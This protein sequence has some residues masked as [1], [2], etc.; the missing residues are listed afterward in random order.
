MS[1]N[2]PQNSRANM[3]RG[4]QFTKK[5]KKGPFKRFIKIVLSLF[6]LLILFGAGLF[7]YYASSSPRITQSALSSD[8]STQI[9]D[10]NGKVISRLGSQNRDYVK[11][12]KIPGTL[13]QAVVSIED[14]RFYKHHGV[15]PIRIVGAA[16]SN[17]TGS[18]LGMQGGSTLTQQLVKL[19]V[20][21]TAASDRTLKRKAQ[22]AW[23]AIQV[24]NRY[25]KSQILEF[26]INKVYMGNGVYGM[27]TGA[28][29]YYN[30]TLG[31]LTLPQLALLAGMPQSPKYYNPYIY[32][33]YATERR[34][35]VLNAMVKNKAIT[36]AQ[37]QRA[38]NTSVKSGLAKTH[39]QTSGSAKTSKYIDS[40]LK[41]TLEELKAKGYKANS[42]LKVYTNLN[43]NAQ[44]KLYKVSNNDPSIV[45]PNNRFQVGAT[46][47]NVNNGKVMAM[48]G[49]RKTKVAF[50]L[51]RA[52]QTG[53]SSGSTAK[54]IMDYG[55]AIEYLKYPTYQPVKDTPYVYP[56][57]D[58]NV[59]D[60]DDKYQGTIT[61]RKAIVE[62]RNI[63]AIRTLENVGISKATTFLK[64]LG[65]PFKKTLSLQNGI[66]LYIS[67]EQLAASYAAFSNGGT[68]Y[69][70]Y[71]INRIV[72]ANGVTKR[73]HPK[74]KR[75]MSPATAF[76]I[77]NMLKGVMTDSDGS[78]TTAKI[79]GLY[80]AGKTGTTQYPDDYLNKV[81]ANSS[82]DAWFS[83]YT[84][85][86]ALAIWTGYDHQFKA[87][88]YITQPQSEI[89]Q[90]I[91]KSVMSYVSQNK[92]NSDW[93]QPSDVV[94][95]NRGGNT[96]YYVA[97][98]PGTVTDNTTT[99]AGS[100]SVESSSSSNGTITTSPRSNEENRG[101]STESSQTA[102]T[103]QQPSGSGSS[104]GDGTD[105]SSSS[106]SSSSTDNNPGT[107][108]SSDGGGSTSD[109]SNN[110]DSNSPDSNNNDVN[111]Q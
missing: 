37:A 7:A 26:Y 83:G 107:G 12:N 100:Y 101:S 52:V 67:S 22:E 17:L 79:S 15:D 72:Q 97:G 43:M 29:F 56:G 66:G 60:F 19:S 58:K 20:F 105:N 3:R 103:T 94:A 45:Y 88:S 21:S 106:T 111:D 70:P 61:M 90:Q 10:T 109:S 31:H 24:E 9:Y 104:S 76:M 63:P 85:N 108:S 16:L 53:R 96:E 71:I 54:P 47:V 62:S 38:K 48:Q 69:K 40:Y 78:G 1:Q 4:R 36:S 5:K 44:K 57:T 92:P 77:T 93:T 55:P 23:L 49:S 99:A 32:P 59:M 81:P 27:Q 89:S 50:G 74:G 68:Y 8:N 18:S 98:Y 25:S 34:N 13:K 46:L 2:N 73:F 64:K 41:Q 95:T 110:Q 65:M 87:N 82:M 33:K 30:K 11:S 86:Y 51:N 91:Y 6:L 42:G 102:P 14:R 35:E 28:E 75:A 39:T 80:E 84:K